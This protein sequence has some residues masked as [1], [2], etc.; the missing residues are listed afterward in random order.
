MRFSNLSSVHA[1]RVNRISQIMRASSRRRFLLAVRQALF[2]FRRA[3]FAGN[4]VADFLKAGKVPWIWKIAALLRLHGLQGTVDAFQE[5]AP[6]IRLFLQGESL[7][8]L[9][10]PGETLDELVPADPLEC[11]EPGDFRIRQTHLPRPAAA[12]RATLAFKKN[13]HANRLCD[14]AILIDRK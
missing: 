3:D 10:Q 5:N 1:R 2:V 9:A 11:G 13:W 8:V 7:P 12:G 6:A 14:Y 4:R